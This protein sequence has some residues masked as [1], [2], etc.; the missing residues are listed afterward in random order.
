[1]KQVIFCFLFTV[2]FSCKE[3]T[4]KPWVTGMENK[5]IADFN[6]LLPDSATY[7][8][9]T[10]LPAGRKTVLFYYSPTCPYCRAQMRE[11]VNNIERYKDVQL[12][13]ITGADFKS[14][15]GFNTYFKLENYPNVITGIDTGNVMVKVYQAYGVPFTAFFDQRKRMIAAYSG[16][17]TGRTLLQVTDP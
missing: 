7:F 9:T 16:R 1:M 4:L 12:L 6:I 5:P 14:M 2:V 11:I 17:I 10:G 15:K 8:N 3:Q 13:V